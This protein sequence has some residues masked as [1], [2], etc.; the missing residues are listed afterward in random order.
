MM[1]RIFLRK[2]F[3]GISTNVEFYKIFKEITKFL[4]LYLIVCTR[5]LVSKRGNTQKLVTKLE[6]VLYPEKV[7]YGL[8][9]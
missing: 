6:P 9:L 8:F 2:Y 4:T 1:S 5:Q 3:S 7:F